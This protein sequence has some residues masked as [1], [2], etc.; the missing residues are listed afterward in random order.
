MKER[1]ILVALIGYIIGILWGLYFTSSIVLCYILIVAI[2]YIRKKFVKNHKKRR[3]KLLSIRRCSKYLK[4]IIDS[5]AIFILIIFS[6]ISNS[7]VLYQNKS[8][9][10]NYKDGEVI[11]FEGIITNQKIEKQYYDLYQLY[12]ENFNM[13]IQVN[14]STKLEY[15]D[16][17]R[18]QGEYKKPSKQRNYGRI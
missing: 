10:E 17:V 9:D 4:L 6:I 15:G 11:S 12:S 2:L 13:Y 8:Y 5:K 16:R 18:L 7:I 1:P 14:K 3:F